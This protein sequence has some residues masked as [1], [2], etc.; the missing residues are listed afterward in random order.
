MHTYVA[1]IHL[2]C[3]RDLMI[4]MCSFYKDLDEQSNWR[5]VGNT[6][7]KPMFKHHLR[8]ILTHLQAVLTSILHIELAR[9]NARTTGVM[10]VICPG[11]SWVTDDQCLRDALAHFGEGAVRCD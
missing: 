6:M 10:K 8:K 2:L 7:N 11:L 9:S 1:L 4:H 5:R 3:C